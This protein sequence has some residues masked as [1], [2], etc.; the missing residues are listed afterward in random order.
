MDFENNTVKFPKIGEIEVVLHKTFEW[1]LKTTTISES[2]TEMYYIS[3]L[4]K[5]EKNFQLNKCF[6]SLRLL[7]Q[8]LE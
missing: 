2:S 7:V 4:E 6:L 1:E 3:I 5:M 8:T